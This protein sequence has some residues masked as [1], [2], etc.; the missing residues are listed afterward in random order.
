MSVAKGL[1]SMNIKGL[2]KDEKLALCQM[3]NHY[4]DGQ[5][6][7]ADE[8]TLPYFTDKLITSVIQTAAN[9]DNLTADGQIMVSVLANSLNIAL[10]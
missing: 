1:S 2:T 3:I 7:E 9:D 6:P 4:S 5:H 10:D 8:S